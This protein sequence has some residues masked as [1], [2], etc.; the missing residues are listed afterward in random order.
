[1]SV[2][3]TKMFPDLVFSR[4]AMV[5]CDTSTAVNSAVPWPTRDRTPGGADLDP[6]WLMLDFTPEGRGVNWYPALDYGGERI[7]PLVF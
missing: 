4:G 7:E 2:G 6:L 5:R 3:K 1:M